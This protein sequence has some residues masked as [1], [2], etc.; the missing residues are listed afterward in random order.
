MTFRNQTNTN[1]AQVIFSK[2]HKAITKIWSVL[3]SFFGILENLTYH[4]H[5]HSKLKRTTHSPQH[6][7]PRPI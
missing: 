3:Q 2:A 5:M 6:C 1:R 7:L 4:T